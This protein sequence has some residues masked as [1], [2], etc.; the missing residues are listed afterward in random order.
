MFDGGRFE[1]FFEVDGI[2]D[3][4][5]LELDGWIGGLSI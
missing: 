2:E 1:G 3:L 5:I 4:D